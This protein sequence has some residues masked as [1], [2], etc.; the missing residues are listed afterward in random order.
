MGRVAFT[1]LHSLVCEMWDPSYISCYLIVV[2]SNNIDVSIWK[3][4]TI[5]SKNMDAYEIKASLAICETQ[6]YLSL[7]L[8]FKWDENGWRYHVETPSAVDVQQSLA[9]ACLYDVR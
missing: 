8:L 7:C 5:Y 1:V 3:K 9:S 2:D 4:M 6:V